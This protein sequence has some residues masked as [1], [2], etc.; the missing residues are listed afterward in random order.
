LVK[1]GFPILGEKP[2]VC[3]SRGLF[4]AIVPEK[5]RCVRANPGV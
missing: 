4:G 5:P 1:R 3:S 2:R